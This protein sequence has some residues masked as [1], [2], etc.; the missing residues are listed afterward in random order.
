M[1]I[2][3]F[4]DIQAW[5]LARKLCKDVYGLSGGG[6]FSKDFGLR[7]QARSAAISVM[8]NISEGFDSHSNREFVH[9]LY[10]AL[11]SASEL[12][13]HLYVALD[14]GY[15]TQVHFARMYEE[16]GKVKSM[17]F[18]FTQYLRNHKRPSAVRSGPQP[19]TSNSESA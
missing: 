14:Q 12:Q 11:R 13:S 7:D 17:I 9:F 1:K 2:T 4:E 16:A 10:Y 6:R 15:I 8:A 19:R 3:K 18:A 5:Q